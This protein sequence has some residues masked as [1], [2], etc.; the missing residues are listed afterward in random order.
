MVDARPFR[1]ESP[2]RI[3][4]RTKQHIVR[5]KISRREHVHLPAVQREL[6][7]HRGAFRKKR[8]NHAAK[9]VGHFDERLL[10]F[11]Q[12]LK[13]NVFGNLQPVSLGV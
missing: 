13:L 12:F 1:V 8:L 4:R 6:L 7:R 5:G 3:S 11:T 2:H 10:L 9:P